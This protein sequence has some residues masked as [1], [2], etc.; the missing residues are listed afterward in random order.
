MQNTEK[1]PNKKARK[2]GIDDIITVNALLRIDGEEKVRRIEL[3][4]IGN[5]FARK[6]RIN[7]D[8]AVMFRPLTKAKK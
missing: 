6:V 5:P 4:F 3:M 8:R 1:F 7:F 2:P